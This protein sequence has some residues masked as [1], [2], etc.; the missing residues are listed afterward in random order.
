MRGWKEDW[1]AVRAP[2]QDNNLYYGLYYRYYVVC[3]DR[4]SKHLKGQLGPPVSDVTFFNQSI[5]QGSFMVF[6]WFPWFSRLFHGFSW[7]S[8]GFHGFSR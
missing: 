7:F 5:F 6:G 1:D 4:S 8:D 3:I 2:K